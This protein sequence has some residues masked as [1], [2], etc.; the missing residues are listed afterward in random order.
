MAL[1]NATGG[2]NW[3]DNENWLSDQP[4][5]SWYGVTTTEGRVTILTLP[6]NG[7]A[8]ELPPDL[9]DLAALQELYLGANQL[10]GRIPPELGNLTNL[11]ALDLT[12]NQLSGEIPQ[13]LAS[14]DSL[15]FM[16]ATRNQLTGCV[17]EGL[18]G[19]NF[20]DLQPC[21]PLAGAPS[22]TPAA[23][24]QAGPNAVPH[25]EAG[26]SGAP[27][28]D[29]RADRSTPS[30]VAT[31]T[32]AP[33]ATAVPVGTPP[34]RQA[35]TATPAPTAT[36]TATPPP[37]PETM[38]T[39]LPPPTPAPTAEATPTPAPPPTLAPTSRPATTP[40]PEIS[41]G[42]ESCPVA[43]NSFGDGVRWI[44][45]YSSETGWLVCDPG[46]TL[47]PEE[48]PLSRGQP[49]PDRSHIG[50]LTHLVGGELYFV[51]VTQE[52]YIRTARLT[53]GWYKV[54]WPRRADE[55]SVTPT[56]TPAPAPPAE[57]HSLVEGLSWCCEGLTL[58]DRYAVR[59]LKHAE[60]EYPAIAQSL[61]DL[62]W[63]RDGMD[64]TYGNEWGVLAV[65]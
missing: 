62:P 28:S 54:V 61:L 60:L 59:G 9:G 64:G 58:Q 39:L 23:I 47:S 21:T 51:N 57:Q 17:P 38:A 4:V 32:L 36:S 10:T 30:A 41:P 56:P 2:P 37:T 16:D 20:G 8:G 31:P 19:F 53:D 13:E 26:P 14:L 45:A 6:A 24:A 55:A 35:A 46:S 50:D 44:A 52:V 27:G 22:P 1:Y 25:A 40:A 33:T 12:R 65:L 7:L 49:V 3:N 29:S 18:Q 48:L 42:A 43:I 11:T 15:V 63:V 5:H 34:P